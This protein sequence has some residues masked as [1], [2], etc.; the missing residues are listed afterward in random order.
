MSSSFDEGLSEAMTYSVFL[1]AT[2][3][4]QWIDPAAVGGSPA[5][6]ALGF[7]TVLCGI[8]V[9]YCSSML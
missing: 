9:I 2:E 3:A 8:A 6:L 1:F 4:F 7:G 5:R